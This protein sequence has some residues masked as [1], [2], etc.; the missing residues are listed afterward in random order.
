MKKTKVIIFI[1]ALVIINS[2]KDKCEDMPERVE[3]AIPDSLKLTLSIGD[4]LIYKSNLDNYDTIIVA[5]I[6]TRYGWIESVD[7]GCYL[8]YDGEYITVS[9]L[10]H[11]TIEYNI[12]QAYKKYPNVFMSVKYKNFNFYWEYIYDVADYYGLDRYY[13]N[14]SIY[15]N[16]CFWDDECSNS[17]SIVIAMNNKYGILHYTDCTGETYDLFKYIKS[18]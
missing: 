6:S 13:Y 18:K 9:F 4:S 15:S 11:D 7:N 3:V 1:L 2:C 14:D 17:E 12:V 10:Y 16:A 8:N 5:D